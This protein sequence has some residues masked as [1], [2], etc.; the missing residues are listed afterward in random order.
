M[1][2]L[3]VRAASYV[4]RS[5]LFADC[6]E[7]WNHFLENDYGF[8]FMEDESIRLTEKST[9]QEALDGLKPATKT[10]DCEKLRGQI[11]QVRE[12]LRTIDDG[13]YIDTAT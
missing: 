8:T 9:L 6:P 2:A 7:L 12:R 1:T 4:R 13:V 5:E 3:L 10:K 11:D